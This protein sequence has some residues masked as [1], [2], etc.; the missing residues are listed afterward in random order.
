MKRGVIKN[1]IDSIEA[2]GPTEAEAISLGL[3]PMQ[4]YFTSKEKRDTA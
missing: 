2:D 4:C 1:N 3:N